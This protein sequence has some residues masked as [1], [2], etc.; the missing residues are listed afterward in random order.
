MIPRTFHQV[1]VGPAEIP[2]DLLRWAW[3]W[4]Y[5]HP[6]WDLVLHTDDP[7]AHQGPWHEVVLITPGVNNH[8]LKALRELIDTG[9]PWQT[10]AAYLAALS[11]VVRM[12]IIA[13]EGGV[14]LDLDVECFKPI[15][16]LLDGVTLF[17][18]DEC[19]PCCGNYLFGARKNH[20]ALW[21]CVRELQTHLAELA[22]QKAL[23]G[24]RVS[25][26]VATGPYYLNLQLR[27][28][29]DLVLFPWPLFNP[30]WAW[31]DPEQVEHWPSVSYSNHRYK[32]TW[33]SRNKRVPPVVFVA[34]G[35]A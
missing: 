6:D 2:E 4:R 21:T 1:W 29:A 3:S 19:G 26:V 15:D 13:R 31:F 24:L 27:K 32:G 30:L 11:D 16:E 9:C 20:P 5:Y 7:D 23:D 33:Y 14:Y 12:E 34:G 18:A 35:A 25:P 28:H 22:E 8:S 10:N 17:C